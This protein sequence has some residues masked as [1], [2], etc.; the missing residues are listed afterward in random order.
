M[1]SRNAGTGHGTGAVGCGARAV[2]VEQLSKG[3]PAPVE[4]LIRLTGLKHRDLI[5][6][7]GPS[8]EALGALAKLGTPEAAGLIGQWLGERDW[9]PELNQWGND[10]ISST[11]LVLFLDFVRTAD[12]FNGG[13]PAVDGNWA[14][15]NKLLNG[16]YIPSFY[17]SH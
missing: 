3:Q 10:E 6:R 16:I 4:E 9:T 17:R 12:A 15:K 11:P 7:L 14:Q 2:L 1:A 13:K 5:H 8:A